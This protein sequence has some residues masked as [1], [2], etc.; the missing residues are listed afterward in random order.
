[1]I[2]KP[3][4]FRCAL[5]FL[6]IFCS[7]MLTTSGCIWTPILTRNWSENYTEEP[8]FENDTRKVTTFPQIVQGIRRFEAPKA[9]NFFLVYVPQGYTPDRAWPVIFCYHGAGGS[10]G[11]FPFQQITRGKGF[12][13]IGMNYATK[14]YHKY[15]RHEHTDPEKALFD[16]ALAIV[17]ARLNI[18]K[19]LI[20]MGGYSQGGY[21]TTVLGEQMLDKLAGL[22]VLGA[23]RTYVD[24]SS[25][26][27]QQIRGKPIFYG[28]GEL[29]EKHNPRARNA[30]EMYRKW[31]AD[32]TFEEWE[33]VE[34]SG[35]FSLMLQSTQMLDWLL[36]NGPLKSVDTKLA[37]AHQA[38]KS[39]KLGKAFTLYNEVSKILPEYKVCIEAAKAAENLAAK[40]EEQIAEA[41]TI[42]QESD[43]EADKLLNQI[44]KVYSGSVYEEFAKQQK[45]KLLNVKA[46]ELEA[47][48]KAAENAK[49]YKK[50][51]YLYELYLT[52]NRQESSRIHAWICSDFYLEVKSERVKMNCRILL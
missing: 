23:G 42:A 22:I 19:E 31:G 4:R 8:A 9:N 49:D 48:A 3:F 40:A 14:Q 50:A 24:R 41:E 33:G 18:A 11:T 1:M 46:N 37:Q 26:P 43:I 17:S 51:L 35:P 13:I 28:V 47:K 20:F 5:V 10:A 36:A 7:I 44:A 32:V 6:F 30:V 2:L 16:E 15:L 25:P 12:I 39:S 21:S 52:K 34:H 27:G 29:D 45:K 38:E